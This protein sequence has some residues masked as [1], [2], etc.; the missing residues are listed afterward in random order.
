MRL[1]FTIPF[2]SDS[3][4][5]SVGIPTVTSEQTSVWLDGL[6]DP[7]FLMSYDGED[8]ARAL[9]GMPDQISVRS[10][11]IRKTGKREFK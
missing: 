11:L 2:Q 4:L 9:L 7:P 5:R 6:L 1:L 8:K 3:E 10:E